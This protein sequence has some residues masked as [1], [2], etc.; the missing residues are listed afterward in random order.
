VIVKHTSISDVACAL[1]SGSCAKETEDGVLDVIWVVQ[2][3]VGVDSVEDV[4]VGVLLGHLTLLE[5][6]RSR[7]SDNG[8]DESKGDD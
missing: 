4:P 1:R 5:G 8:A 6:K 3:E 2:E 7:A